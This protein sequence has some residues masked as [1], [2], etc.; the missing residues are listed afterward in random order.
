VK[1]LSQNLNMSIS[2]GIEFILKSFKLWD[3]FIEKWYV[4]EQ[5]YYHN[6]DWG[7]VLILNE[8]LNEH[9]SLSR[10]TKYGKFNIITNNKKI[11]FKID[12]PND[13]SIKKIKIDFLEL[14]EGLE[15]QNE[16]ITVD[17]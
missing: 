7:T 11:I 9:K 16:D 15:I 4:K 17:D 10:I 13:K 6:A 3:E 5:S 12:C 2:Q 8:F 14:K 1:F